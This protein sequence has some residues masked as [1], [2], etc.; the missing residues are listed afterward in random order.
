M[1]S[2][3]KDNRICKLS[4]NFTFTENNKNKED[5]LIEKFILLIFIWNIKC[6]MSICSSEGYLEI[7]II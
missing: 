3:F 5:M 6:L 2:L 7:C 1:M 4:L